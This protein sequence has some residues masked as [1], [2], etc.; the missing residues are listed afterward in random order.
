MESEKGSLT[1]AT[2]NLWTG[3][4]AFLKVSF[5]VWDLLMLVGGMVRGKR[6]A[7]WLKVKWKSVKM[8]FSISNSQFLFLLQSFLFNL[9]TFQFI[10]LFFFLV[11]R[12][13]S[14][15][16]SKSCSWKSP[17]LSVCPETTLC[18]FLRSSIR[19]I[20][21]LLQFCSLHSGRV[22]ICLPG[23]YQEASGQPSIDIPGGCTKEL[24]L[25]P[26]SLYVTVTTASLL[27]VQ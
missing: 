12:N 6:H 13:K 8:S 7:P 11:M 16:S 21:V 3:E 25:Y 26:V 24:Q 2:H 22:V 20:T 4:S 15:F 19:C 10:Y 17:N 18:N 27:T 5:C 9:V 23:V 14:G 1:S